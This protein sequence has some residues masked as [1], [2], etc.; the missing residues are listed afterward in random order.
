MGVAMAHIFGDFIEPEGTEGEYLKIGFS[1][2]A[3]PIQQRWR[4]N[5]LSADFIA[6]YLSSFFPGEDQASVARQAEI[7]AAVSYVA[8]ELLE[9]AMKFNYTPSNHAVSIEMYLEVAAIVLYVTNS[10]APEAVLRFQH[11]IKRLLTDDP[12]DLYM[13]RLTHNAEADSEGDSGLGFLTMLNDYQAM[14]AWKFTPVK[15]ESDL[16]LVTTMVRLT[17]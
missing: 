14:L 13:E 7:K 3:I 8:N 6:D 17:I 15:S 10:V 4:N 12:G 16:T 9:N 1:P 2:T 11:L 5:G